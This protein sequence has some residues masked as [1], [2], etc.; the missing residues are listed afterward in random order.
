MGIPA[1]Y[2]QTTVVYG[3][4]GAPT[5]AVN[6]WG[7]KNDAGFTAAEA[8][9]VWFDEWLANVLTGTYSSS[10]NVINFKVKLGPDTTGPSAE[11]PC[12]FTGGLATAGS[13]AVCYLLQ[14]ITATGGRAGRGRVY[15]PGAAETDISPDGVVQ[16]A[17]RDQI[18]DRY[19]NL[20]ADMIAAGIPLVLLH[21]SEL[22]PSP[23][24]DVNCAP[25]CAT[26]RRRVRR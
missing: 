7:F 18:T 22:T 9:E 26:Q 5:G 12:T 14:K 4:L 24:I 16:A 17:N 10:V 20:A 23:V 21:G 19:T 15:I 11:R 3:G 1:G 8:A 25:I 2:G 6:T 13:P